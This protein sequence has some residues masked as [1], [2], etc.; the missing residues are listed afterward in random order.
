MCCVNIVNITKAHTVV[1]MSTLSLHA[2]S[3][4][5]VSSKFYNLHSDVSLNGY[6]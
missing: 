6:C 3:K 1:C 5:Y 2:S 4:V